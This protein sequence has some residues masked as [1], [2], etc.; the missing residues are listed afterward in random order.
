MAGHVRVV[1]GGAI[2]TFCH[3]SSNPKIFRF[4]NFKNQVQTENGKVKKV[5]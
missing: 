4:Q 5:G 2:E 3:T 1:Q